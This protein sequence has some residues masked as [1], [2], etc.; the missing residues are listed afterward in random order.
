VLSRF[1]QSLLVRPCVRPARLAVARRSS[2]SPG[3]PGDL[4]GQRGGGEPSKGEARVFR[5]G[6]ALRSRAGTSY[7]QASFRFRELEGEAVPG[8]GFHKSDAALAFD[9]QPYMPGARLGAVRLPALAALGVQALVLGSLFSGLVAGG[10]LGELNGDGAVAGVV[11]I[12]LSAVLCGAVLDVRG[13]RPILLYAPL[14]LCILLSYAVNA[15]D[16]STGSARKERQQGRPARPD[17]A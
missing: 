16:A 1:L 13:A 5:A 6:R 4:V 12:V 8:V 11:I 10:S 17:Q 15:D 9:D 7:G 14:V 3:G 2:S